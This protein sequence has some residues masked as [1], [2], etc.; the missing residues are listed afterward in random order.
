MSAF[1]GNDHCEGFN[2]YMTLPPGDFKPLLP[3]SYT[4]PA[5]IPEGAI[6]DFIPDRLYS[7]EELLTYVKASRQKARQLIDSLTEDRLS[8]RFKEE[9]EEEAM[10]SHY[11]RSCCIICAMCSI[12]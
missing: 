8:E 4:E 11:W 3:F 1:P 5:D 10:D 2:D 12:M 9:L 6:D 7:K